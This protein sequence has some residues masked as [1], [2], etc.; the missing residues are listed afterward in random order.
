MQ[1]AKGLAAESDRILVFGSFLTVAGALEALRKKNTNSWKKTTFSC[2]LKNGLDAVWS[3]R[4]PLFRWLLLSCR[5]S[6]ITSPGRWFRMLKSV[7]PARTKSRLRPNFRPHPSRNRSTSLPTHLRPNRRLKLPNPGARR[8]QRLGLWK[9]PKKTLDKPVE[10]NA[11]QSREI[12]RKATREIY[13]ERLAPKPAENQRL[14]TM[15]PSGRRQFL[16]GNPLT[17]SQC[18]HPVNIW[19]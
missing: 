1:A 13:R 8:S 5:W 6:W 7:F 3:V 12:A 18:R 4:L 10:N 16:V 17:P 19:C 2:T 15:M 11:G 9:R 14:K